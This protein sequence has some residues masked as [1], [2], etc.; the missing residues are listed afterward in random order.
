MNWKV[1]VFRTWRWFKRQFSKWRKTGLHTEYFYVHGLNNIP[2]LRPA[3]IPIEIRILELKEVELL[4]QIWL[5]DLDK[6]RER[7]IAGHSCCYLSLHEGKPVAYHWVQLQGKHFVQQAG[8]WIDIFKN[9]S[10]MIYH[11]RVK[12]EYQ[13][14]GINMYLLLYILHN[15][16]KL[17]YHKGYIYTSSKNIANQKGI[18]RIGFELKDKVRSFKVGMHFYTTK[19]LSL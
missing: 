11:T 9:D 2:E 6:A 19:R 15:F 13:K 16:R 12:C 8:Q 3:N 14:N 1:S 10:F 7:L 5:V 4:H 18:E 17:G